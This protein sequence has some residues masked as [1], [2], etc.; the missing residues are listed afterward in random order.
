M[1]ASNIA[2]SDFFS[3]QQRAHSHL[4]RWDPTIKPRLKLTGTWERNKRG[5]PK[6]QFLRSPDDGTT[7]SNSNTDST[8]T[9]S[10]SGIT[11]GCIRTAGSQARASRLLSSKGL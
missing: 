1:I 3:P 11:I 7:N 5:R 8:R 4:G 2:P 6:A 9:N 10:N